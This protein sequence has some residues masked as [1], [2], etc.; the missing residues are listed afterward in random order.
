MQTSTKMARSLL[1][2][3]ALV[4]T[5]SLAHGQQAACPISASVASRLDFKP[6]AA[7]CKTGPNLCTA[8]ICALVDAFAPALAATPVDPA[9]VTRD[10]ANALLN[11]C[12]PTFLGPLSRAGVSLSAL[13]NVQNCDANNLPPCIE[14]LLPAATAASGP[15][16]SP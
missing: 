7:A 16:G 8:C 5:L 11:A 12:A 6:A 1:L 4:L 10:S 2:A 3:L 15:S 14:K 9:T 13:L